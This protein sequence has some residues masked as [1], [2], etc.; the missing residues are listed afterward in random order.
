MTEPA[1]E[2]ILGRLERPAPGAAVA[3]VVAVVGWAL[4]RGGEEAEIEVSID[5][6]PCPARVDRWA[7]P[8]VA[9]EVPAAAG[10]PGFVA[11]VNA[12]RLEN[13]PHRIA[14]A[15]R[16]D[17]ERR[18]VGEAAVE[19]RNE[20][21][22]RFYRRAVVERSP[23]WQRAKLERMLPILACPSCRGEVEAR[24]D[25]RLRC[26]SCAREFP[27][28]DGVPCMTGAPLEAPASFAIFDTPY[29]PRLVE[30][31]EAVH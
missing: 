25:A 15:A 26:A 3:R 19:V 11:F 17:G 20:A 16:V 5:G 31:L 9:R 22:H 21:A 7:R 24:G 12:A 28:R 30:M 13:G 6:A 23:A 27:M 2:T 10:A 8:D 4:G 1:R 14:C 18:A 29:D